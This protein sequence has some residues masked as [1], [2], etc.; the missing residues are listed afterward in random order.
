M[1]FQHRE[2]RKVIINITSLIDVVFLLLIFFMITTTFV[3]QPGITLDLPEAQATAETEPEE[4]VLVISA[5][6]EI[7][8]DQ[9]PVEIDQLTTRLAAEFKHQA[10]KSLILRADQAVPHGTV[11]KVMDIAKT[12]GIEKLIVAT[13]LE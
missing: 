8:L 5:E 2:R 1:Q 11:V 4:V 7:F 13:T 9:D 10:G 6:G 3:E 12:V